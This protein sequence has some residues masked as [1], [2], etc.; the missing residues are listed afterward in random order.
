MTNLPKFP[1]DEDKHQPET[2]PSVI[3]EK[4]FSRYRLPDE[5]IDLSA[6][7]KDGMAVY[8][9]FQLMKPA[10]FAMLRANGGTFEFSWKEA[11]DLELTERIRFTP[12]VVDDGT[13][14]HIYTITTEPRVEPADVNKDYIHDEDK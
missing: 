1:V 13:Y 6:W 2:D 7:L 10:F 8:N 12:R 5:A 9:L 14:D 11:N 3:I 4:R